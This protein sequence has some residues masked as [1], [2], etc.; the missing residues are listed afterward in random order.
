MYNI[1]NYGAKSNGKI[2]SSKAF[3]SAWD[4]ACASTSPAT[5]YVPQGSYLLK[6][7]YFHGE[8][9]KSKAITL[10]IDGNILAPSDYNVNRN[11]ENWIKFERVNGVSIYGG[12]L[13]GQATSLWACKTSGNNCPQGTMVRIF[14]CEK[15]NN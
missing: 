12:T 1:K 8:T 2:D 13:D 15:N 6:N 5:I 11:E 3:M 14:I 9:C 7:A 4:A 10:R